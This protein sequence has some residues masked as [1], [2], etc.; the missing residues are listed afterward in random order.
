MTTSY[1]IL[2]L[3]IKKKDFPADLLSRDCYL[4]RALQAT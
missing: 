2:F 3:N 1:G 4:E